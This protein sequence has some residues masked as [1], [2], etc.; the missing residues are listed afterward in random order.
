MR[1]LALALA[2]ALSSVPAAA[3]MPGSIRA[4]VLSNDSNNDGAVTKAEAQAF[5]QRTFAGADSDHNGSLN[6]AERAST[7]PMGQAIAMADAN[8]DSLV[9]LAEFMAAPY[10]AFDTFDANHND[11][12]EAGEI[13][14]IP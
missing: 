9:S 11:I 7:G 10:R 1:I 2:L 3:Q 12:L 5:R 14:R 6:A 13:A 8:G 4:L